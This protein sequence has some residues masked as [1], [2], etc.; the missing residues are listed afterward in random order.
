MLKPKPASVMQLTTKSHVAGSIACQSPKFQPQE[1]ISTN[2]WM[3]YALLQLH[4]FTMFDLVR[5]LRGSRDHQIL[6]I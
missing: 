1:N 3:A 4:R 5:K 2:E 6:Q